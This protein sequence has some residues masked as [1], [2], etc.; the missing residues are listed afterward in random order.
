MRVK[1][2]V[3]PKRDCSSA[4]DLFDAKAAKGAKTAKVRAVGETNHGVSHA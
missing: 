2:R 3:D 4:S 1:N